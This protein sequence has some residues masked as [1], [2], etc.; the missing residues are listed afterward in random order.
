M[1]KVTGI[2]YE[3]IKSYFTGLFAFISAVIVAVSL[4][5]M[6][7][8]DETS[9]NITQYS[10][11]MSL[12]IVFGILSV[13][14]TAF[15]IYYFLSILKVEFIV[16]DGVMAINFFKGDKIVRSLDVEKI[17]FSIVV[18]HSNYLSYA[19]RLLL[20]LRVES[21]AGCFFLTENLDCNKPQLNIERSSFY[22]E[23]Y[24]CRTPGTLRELFFRLKPLDM[25]L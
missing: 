14:F 9:K 11:S 24:F 21:K 8:V 12:V 6:P 23:N 1:V 2:V 10:D 17:E 22:V 16:A 7:S 20:E 18:A 3:R 19:L 5:N 15:S 4:Y 13:V 25:K